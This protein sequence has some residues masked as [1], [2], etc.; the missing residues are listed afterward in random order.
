MLSEGLKLGPDEAARH[1]EVRYLTTG[2]DV[3][4]AGISVKVVCLTR[5]GLASCLVLPVPRGS[6]TWCEKSAEGIVGGVTSRRGMPCP[7]NVREPDGLTN[8]GTA[9]LRTRMAGGVSLLLPISVGL[10]GQTPAVSQV[11][12]SL[13]ASPERDRSGGTV[14]VSRQE[15][16]EP[17]KPGYGFGNRRHTRRQRPVLVYFEE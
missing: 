16:A 9:E 4:A 10:D 15:A 8:L 5:G 1:T 12:E 13:P 17:G 14:S 6:G 7:V 2:T 11:S 3:N